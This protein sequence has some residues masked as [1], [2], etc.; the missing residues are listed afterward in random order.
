MAYA[1]IMFATA[2]IFGVVAEQIYKGK[3]DFI[4]DYHQ[5]N[6]TD[7]DGYGRAFGKAMGVIAGAMVLSGLI[8]LFGESAIWGAIGILAVGLIVGIIAIIRVQKKFNGGV[9]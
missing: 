5:T 3:T 7:R 1:I 8:A 9:F 4:H 2:V 6:V